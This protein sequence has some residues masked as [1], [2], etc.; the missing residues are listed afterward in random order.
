MMQRVFAALCAGLAVAGLTGCAGSGVG[1]AGAPHSVARPTLYRTFDMLTGPTW[2]G[3]LTY[4]NYS[5]GEWVTIPCNVRVAAEHSPQ[6][7]AQYTWSTSYTDEP[8]ADGAT[9]VTVDAVGRTISMG[10]VQEQIV[11]MTGTPYSLGSQ[12]EV[13]VTEF[14]GED[15]ARPA[16]IRKVYTIGAKVLSVQKLV[17][18]DG[19]SRDFIERHVYRWHR[20]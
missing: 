6:T 16:T 1:S 11:A 14:A 7:R 19:S 20:E 8:H 5:D 3:T 9:L 12:T 10:D 15:D 17:R 13:L 4:R 2:K 18:W